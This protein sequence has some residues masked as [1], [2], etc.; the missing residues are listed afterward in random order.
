MRIADICSQRVVCIG[1]DASITEAAQLMHDQDVGALVV[2]RDGKREPI[3]IVTDRD[4]VT[5]IVASGRDPRAE[6]V[7]EAMSGAPAT[8]HGNHDLLDVMEMMRQHGIR[9]VPVVD[10]QSALIG[11]VTT[12][13]IIGAL[14]EHVF[15]LARSV[16]SE[17]AFERRRDRDADVA[18]SVGKRAGRV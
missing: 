13:D 17:D 6:P 16:L 9:R 18:G 11:I 10:A 14:A 7:S 3:G 1:P 15:V 5:R 2:T 12:D 8:C 4:I